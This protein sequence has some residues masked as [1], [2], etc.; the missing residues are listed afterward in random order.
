MEHWWPGDFRAL[1]DKLLFMEDI[2]CMLFIHEH[3]AGILN[4][5]APLMIWSCY[6]DITCLDGREFAPS[7]LLATLLYC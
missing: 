2:G 3:E 6:C 1:R 7:T 5:G 4:D